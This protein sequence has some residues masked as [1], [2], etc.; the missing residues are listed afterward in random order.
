[1]NCGIFIMEPEGWPTNGRNY[2]YTYTTP[3]YM[4]E[5]TRIDIVLKGYDMLG[6]DW[7]A[8]DNVTYDYSGYWEAE[9][10]GGSS[11]G[12]YVTTIT[13]ADNA[14]NYGIYDDCI[15]ND[16]LNDT[17]SP[18]ISPTMWPTYTPTPDPTVPS[19]VPTLVP[20]MAPTMA[21]TVITSIP[22]AVPTTNP[23]S[24][25]TKSPTMSPTAVV[26]TESTMFIDPFIGSSDSID[27]ETDDQ[28]STPKLTP[29]PTIIPTQRPT[30][31]PFSTDSHSQRVTD[32]MS[33]ST[34]ISTMDSIPPFSDHP[35]TNGVDQLS[36]IVIGIEVL[37]VLIVIICC[38][39][40][41]Y[42]VVQWNQRK[43]KH[44]QPGSIDDVAVLHQTVIQTPI[45]SVGND[46]VPQC[47]PSAKNT[48][49]SITPT[50]H[51]Q[52]GFAMPTGHMMHVLVEQD[53]ELRGDSMEVMGHETVIGINDSSDDSDHFI[54]GPR[55][56]DGLEVMEVMESPI[57]SPMETPMETPME[58]RI[59]SP[60]LEGV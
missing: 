9:Y 48:P 58:S 5:I 21:P 30:N 29:N 34:S 10:N 46:V 35:I 1:M 44:V 37:A 13:T 45:H 24:E 53:M 32:P 39:L 36:F 16:I 50:S 4:G 55:T 49:S 56:D 42:G 22:T 18:T 47:L 3:K 27:Y 11:K 52:E 41:V 38:V 40:C 59:E 19:A 15:Y 7:I 25:P 26:I 28:N 57:E 20:T 60:G 33:I 54:L 6:I 23:S 14:W 8:V 2:N 43:R 17:Y 31:Y 51:P 12:C